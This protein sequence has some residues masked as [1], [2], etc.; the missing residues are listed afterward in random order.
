MR[1]VGDNIRAD[2]YRA[3]LPSRQ[4][5]YQSSKPIPAPRAKVVLVAGSVSLPSRESCCAEGDQL[6]MVVAAGVGL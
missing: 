1:G 2:D 4:R 5:A 3:G 6:R